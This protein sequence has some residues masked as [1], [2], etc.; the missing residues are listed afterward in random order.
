MSNPK[1]TATGRERRRFLKA[2]GAALAGWAL[3]PLTGCDDEQ[4]STAPSGR[5]V[6]SASRSSVDAFAPDVE[7]RLAAT[8][9]TI[10]LPGG[11]SWNTWTYGGQYPGPEIRAREGERLRVI[12]EN[13]LPDEAGTTIH[14]HGVPVP[15][16]MDG[17]PNV[18][19]KPTPPGARFAYEFEAT[20]AGTYMYHSHAGLQ[21]DRGLV[22]PLIIEERTPHVE[23]DREHTVI[24][25][26]FLPGPPQP[27]EKLVGN[28]REG[29]MMGGGGRSMMQDRRDGIVPPYEGLMING[30]L[31]EDPA[32]FDVQQG[33][34]VRLRLVNPSSATTYHLAL[35]GHRLTVTHADGRP[36]EPVEVD[37]LRIGMGERYD[38]IVE[39]NNPGAHTL[40]AR[41]IEG[42]TAPAR[43][44][45]RYQESRQNRPPDGEVPT[46]LQSGRRLRYADLQ[47]VETPLGPKGKPDRDFNLRLSGGMMMSPGEWAIDG[48]R[49]PDA[50]PLE[51]REGEHVHVQM[52]NHSMM[53]HPMHLHGHFFRVGNALKDT[54]LV[55]PHMGR[56]SFNF[57]ADNPGDWF[58]HCHNLYH[59]E[60]GMARVFTYA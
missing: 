18:T 39:A 23:Y 19:Q 22:G 10:E 43:A 54:V 41:T 5:S 60:A 44:T 7:R 38:V 36:V 28:G 3:A 13:G 52:T 47:S 25:D 37:S 16:V 29:G 59:L 31:P 35:A 51:V 6:L 12:V 9:S 40:M 46:G 1:D 42:D 34:R 14:W 2:G 56:A 58:F 30:R 55:E 57:V 53:L 32:T 11:R 50:D 17:V 20:P 8:S 15:N 26:D 4:R 27:L 21:L 45:L 33:E 48:Q 49:Y 24:L